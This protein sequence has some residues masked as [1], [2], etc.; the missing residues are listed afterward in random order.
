MNF[1]ASTTGA[2]RAALD[3]QLVQ[4]YLQGDQR[5][6][7]D[8]VEYHRP[9]M[10]QVAYQF[11]RNHHDA[12]EAA[13]T[14]MVRMINALP[15]WR[16]DS[17]LATWLSTICANVSRNK[18]WY[19]RRR[20]SRETVSMDAECPDSQVPISALIADERL[21]HPSEDID[22]E[23]FQELLPIAINALNDR[24]RL[25]FELK[26]KQK[27]DYHQIGAQMGINIGTVKSCLARARY[28]LREA[29]REQHAPLV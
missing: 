16:G 4:S 7:V 13:A 14:T 15:N 12:E 20:R 19:N 18:Y 21:R 1:Q 17:S 3:R 27:M 28:K 24:H 29:L 10:F 6:L 22:A 2:E 26:F 25:I 9:R 11:L 23:T 5:A 8:I